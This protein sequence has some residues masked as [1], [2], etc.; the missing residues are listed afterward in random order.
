MGFIIV[1]VSPERAPEGWEMD[2]VD[3]GHLHW[4]LRFPHMVSVPLLA[5]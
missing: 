1:F 3:Y 5:K 2:V 4:V